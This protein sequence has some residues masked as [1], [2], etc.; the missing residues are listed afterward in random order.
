MTMREINWDICK[1]KITQCYRNLN[2]KGVMSI[3]QK[4]NKSWLVVGHAENLILR[5][6]TFQISQASHNR[7]IKS[8]RKNVHAWSIDTID[9]LPSK[10]PEMREIYYCPFS[11]S[12][13]TWKESGAVIERADYLA[14]IDTRV[15]CSI[16]TQSPQFTLF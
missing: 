3:R 1:N 4:V 6:V 8:G 7:A 12:Q 11:Q 5:N 9:I 15:Y 2:Q 14:V 10:L 13:F 16:D